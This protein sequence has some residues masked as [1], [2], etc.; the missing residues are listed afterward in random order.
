M[1]I[2]QKVTKA[3]VAAARLKSGAAI[4]ASF[5]AIFTLREVRR[6][7]DRL[8]DTWTPQALCGALLEGQRSTWPLEQVRF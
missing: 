8:E 2:Q 3:M 6:C 5:S 4:F 7:L 1:P